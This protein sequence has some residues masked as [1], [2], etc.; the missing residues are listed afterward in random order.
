VA[1]GDAAGPPATPEDATVPAQ[2]P[3]G[4]G[5]PAAVRS[6]RVQNLPTAMEVGD[7]VRLDATAL[8]ASGAVVDRG[9]VGWTVSDESVGRITGDGTFTARAPGSVDVIA[10]V[11]GVR[12]R[13]ATSVRPASVAS[14]VVAPSSLALT[15]G[16]RERVVA[17][18][19]D[20]TGNAVGDVPVLWTSGDATVAT[21][22]ADGEVIAVGAGRTRLT[23]AVEGVESSAAVSVEAAPVDARTAIEDLI[24]AY[25][26][27]LESGDIGEVRRVNT[28][29]TEQQARETAGALRYM[30]DLAVDL[31]V[32]SFEDHGDTATA[33]VVGT[34]RFVT[35]DS[36]RRQELPV[37]FTANFE[38]YVAG[39]RMTGSR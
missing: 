10:T 15:V 29:M 24:G 25:A 1:D 35:A 14:V 7:A 39:W 17:D 12:G 6:V 13:G 16:E 19:R 28:G 4:Q 22:S 2:P 8:N 9:S 30:Q 34:Y 32:A 20:R 21:V 26:R 23:A 11:G 27:A 37:T 18:V 5:Q 31:R 33:N 38:R 3:A 36:G